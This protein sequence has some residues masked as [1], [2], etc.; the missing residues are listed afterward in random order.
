MDQEPAANKPGGTAEVP[1][2]TRPWSPWARFGSFLVFLAT[3]PFTWGET[4]SCNGPTRTYTGIEQITQTKANI[5]PFV[6]IFGTP[7]LLG[8]LQFLARTAWFRLGMESVAALFASLGTLHCFLAGAIGGNL[9]TKNERVYVAPWVATLA[10][11]LV[12]IDA[13]WCAVQQIHILMW[14]RGQPGK[15]PKPRAEIPPDS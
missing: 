14:A 7:I 5:I 2:K 11:L 6:I 4:S 8:F 13:F 9:L 10:M 3:L 15:T 12:L 1:A